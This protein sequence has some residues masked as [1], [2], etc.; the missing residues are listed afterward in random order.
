M[1]DYNSDGI[2]DAGQGYGST[3][4]GNARLTIYCNKCNNFVLTFNEGE[5]VDTAYIKQVQA[6]LEALR[7]EKEKLKQALS[8]IVNEDC[9]DHNPK[10]QC[11]AYHVVIAQKALE[12]S[13]PDP[14]EKE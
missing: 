5:A 6:E 11:C 3:N 8:R 7:A 13:T 10:L 9:P 14:K 4:N 12:S 1:S 2:G